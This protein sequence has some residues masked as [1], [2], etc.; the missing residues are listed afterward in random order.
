MGNKQK[1]DKEKDINY[2]PNYFSNYI[3]CP[4]CWKKIP[5]LYIFIEN[6]IPKIKIICSCF[7]D[8]KKSII[9]HLEAFIN[10]IKNKK[11][12]VY[13]C[14]NHRDIKGTFFCLNCENWLCDV[15]ENNHYL[16]NNNKGCDNK[17]NE[18]NGIMSFC[19]RHSSEKKVYFCKNCKILFCRFCFLNHNIKKE[20]EHKGVNILNYLT[21]EKIKSKNN[22]NSF[23]IKNIIPYNLELKNKI[24]NKIQIAEKKGKDEKLSKLKQNIVESHIK[25]K[26][27]NEIINSFIGLIMMNIEYFKEKAITNKKFIINIINNTKYNLNI[28]NDSKDLSLEEES[29]NC[30]DYFKKNY[31]NMKLRAEIK[32]NNNFLKKNE[33]KIELIELLCLL[34]ENIFASVDSDFIIKIWEIQTG[35]NIY[36]FNEHTNNITSLLKLNNNFLGS[37]SNDKT[38]KIWDYK[39]GKCIK[40]IRIK[41]NPYIIFNIHG[42]ND[43]IGC[44]PNRNSITVYDYSQGNYNKIIFEKNLENIIPWIE[45]FYCFP[46]DKRII[47][48]YIGFFSVFSAE[49]EEIKRITIDNETPEIFLQINNGD[50][51]VGLLGNQIFIYDKNLFFKAKLIGHNYT[52]AG[53]FQLEEKILLSYSDNSIVKLWNLGT[54]EIIETFFN[55]EDKI[56]SLIYIGNKKFICSNNNKGNNIEKWEIE[57]H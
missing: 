28:P 12:D 17:I 44:I 31:I 30:L 18:E 29:S 7:N 4:E 16:K 46:N 3:L 10:L 20:I 53:L 21:K 38:I 8:H 23:Y 36:I 35:K 41:S 2:I 48:S 32:M 9:L 27:A 13:N 24:I 34:N 54:N 5:Y 11:H 19:H 51:I 39:I 49:I 22:K 14:L 47:L 56:N 26:N 43:L 55:I 15:C 50:L 52:I 1:S 33:E 37:A 6:D 45:G 42:K 40:T 57:I 25:N